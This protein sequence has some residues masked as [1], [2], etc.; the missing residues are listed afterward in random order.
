MTQDYPDWM[1]AFYLYGVEIT[2][3]INIESS[4]ITL[5]ISIDAV[6]AELSFTL[7]ASDIT[8]PISLD[9]VNVTLD[10][11]IESQDA[12]IT[13]EFADQSVAVFDAAKWFAHQ[14][15]QWAI[16]SE[17]SKAAT[18]QLTVSRTVPAN[19]VGYL[20]GIGV[21]YFG[22]PAAFN[23]YWSISVAGSVVAV[24]GFS[25]G[26][27]VILDVPFRATAGQVLTII[28]SNW[29]GATIAVGGS[30]WGYDEAA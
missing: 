2:I 8:L 21:G 10:V 9:A 17:A 1:R 18:A 26:G 13:F 24:G 27:T 6:T 16:F 7:H 5:P 23:I 15:S 3:P 30:F 19:K 29:S 12:N 22:V 28:V 11:N 25:Y 14:G 20:L 4:D